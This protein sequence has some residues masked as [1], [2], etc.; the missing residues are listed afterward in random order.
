MLKYIKDHPVFL[1]KRKQY[2]NENFDQEVRN[3]DPTVKLKYRGMQFM[4]KYANIFVIET[5]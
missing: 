5:L 3:F 2:E 4:R 1:I